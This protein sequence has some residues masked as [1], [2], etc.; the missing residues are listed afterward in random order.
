MAGA[1]II[2]FIISLLVV[3]MG[4][5]YLRGKAD[6]LIAG[7]N[8]AT[9]QY[10]KM[11]DIKRLRLLVAILHFV[12]GGLFFLFLMKDSNL[13]VTIFLSSIAV[14]STVIIIL[15]RTWAKKTNL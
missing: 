5:L 6:F 3:L 8:T 7:F 2:I 14:V 1:L 10:Q 9:P 12:L 4:I 11:Y 13:A 15:A